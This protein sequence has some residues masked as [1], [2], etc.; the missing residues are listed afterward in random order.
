MDIWPATAEDVRTPLLVNVPPLTFNVMLL[1]VATVIPELI[2]VPPGAAVVVTTRPPFKLST[3]PTAPPP[4][5]KLR[6]PVP[7][8]AM[9]I[10]PPAD[11][12]DAVGAPRP[13]TL[14]STLLPAQHEMFITV[15]AL[16][17]TREEPLFITNDEVV[18]LKAAPWD[19]V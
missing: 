6:L 18:R 8:G 11:T 15:A 9:E 10:L 7:C 12:M 13:E 17:I 4:W 5:L 14:I 19:E 16:V 2:M 1:F 3:A